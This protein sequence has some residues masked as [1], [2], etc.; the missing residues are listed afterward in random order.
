MQ[1]RSS[2]IAVALA[3]VFIGL[4]LVAFPQE[5]P[6]PQEPPPP[7]R[8][9]PKGQAPKPRLDLYGDPL[10]EGAVARMGTVRLRQSDDGGLVALSKNGEFIAS[11]TNFLDNAVYVWDR[12]TGRRLH[13]I[14]WHP[15]GCHDI[16]ISPDDTTIATV[17]MDWTVHLWDVKTGQETGR[18]PGAIAVVF[19]PDGRHIAT[20]DYRGR[21]DSKKIRIWNLAQGRE[22]ATFRGRPPFAFT[23]DGKLFAWVGDGRQLLVSEWTGGG[24]PT[25]V[26]GAVGVSALAFSPDGK[27]VATGHREDGSVR[28]WEVGTW[29]QQGLLKGHSHG[30]E[31]LAYTS[32]GKNL[33]TSAKEGDEEKKGHHDHSGGTYKVLL[34]EI[35]TGEVLYEMEGKRLRVFTEGFSADGKSMTAVSPERVIRLWDV[36]TGKSQLEFTGHAG[37]VTSVTFSQDGKV[38]ATASGDRSEGD[39]AIHLWDVSTGRHLREIRGHT[40][41]VCSVSFAPDGKSLVSGS[42]D[43]TVRLWSPE[44]GEPEKVLQGH[45]GAVTFVGF[46]EANM[47]ITGSLDKTL[48]AWDAHTGKET[49]VHQVGKEILSRSA[50]AAGGS[51]FAIYDGSSSPAR[52]TVWDVR[53]GRVMQRVQAETWINS[54]SL[55]PD[56]RYLITGGSEHPE[57]ERNEVV[58]WELATA[59]LVYRISGEGDR[60]SAVAFSWDGRTFAWAEGPG[61]NKADRHYPIHVH[62][63][64]TGK[65]ILR[66]DEQSG[67]AYALAFS[68]DGTKLASGMA[69]TTALVWDVSVTWPIAPKD[70]VP[71]PRQLDALWAELAGSDAGAAFLAVREIARAGDGAISFL[72]ERIV[73]GR[74]DSP[75]AIQGLIA[76]LDH[77]EFQTRERATSELT[78]MGPEMAATFEQALEEAISPE[79]KLRLRSILTSLESDLA[80]SPGEPLRRVRAIQALELVGTDAAMEFLGRLSDQAPLR[81]ERLQTRAALERLEGR[82]R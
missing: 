39:G 78:A 77:D 5:A 16:S 70:A 59:A 55:S 32:D 18:F 60:V 26:K 47:L 23:P 58:L 53:S 46:N 24:D 13:R 12:A 4:P 40:E 9:T 52:A 3:V 31:G 73:L 41:S 38:L 66:F 33:A 34:R 14:R 37:P 10:P 44:T 30:V 62:R 49:G 42:H 65:E 25:T 20:V 80:L 63:L 71:D 51:A 19:S 64:G 67:L 61:S 79:V 72:Q 2:H 8:Q 15:Y 17:G 69:D 75:E 11:T 6:A 21:G 54:V 81:R 68:P 50:L 28:L 29:K 76:D 74:V 48:R 82:G 1:Y 27:T 57:T 7:E 22:V 36:E 43:G 35:A 45:G 56:G